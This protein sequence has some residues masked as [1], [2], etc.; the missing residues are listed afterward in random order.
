MV[1][2][3]Y[4]CI[5]HITNGKCVRV[6][7][8]SDGLANIVFICII[9]VPIGL[10][11]ISRVQF[12]VCAIAFPIQNILDAQQGIR[13]RCITVITG[14]I[15]VHTIAH[16][17]NKVDDVGIHNRAGMRNT[18]QTKC[19]IIVDATVECLFCTVQTAVI[20]FQLV[21]CCTTVFNEV[22][23]GFLCGVCN[24]IID[25]FHGVHSVIS[26][27]TADCKQHDNCYNHIAHAFEVFLCAA[28]HE[29]QADT[30]DANQNDRNPDALNRINVLIAQ[31]RDD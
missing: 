22:C 2:A 9:I 30:I 12:P 3:F 17:F 25:F 20:F 11:N 29:V 1:N 27:F 28:L 7:I 19:T 16:G 5:C 4:I 14:I 24:F 23:P 8:G 10:C 13:R 26:Q 21:G 15:A 6:F 18:T 31:L